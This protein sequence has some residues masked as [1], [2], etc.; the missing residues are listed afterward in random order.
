MNR[1]KFVEHTLKGAGALA[2]TGCRR[3]TKSMG[4]WKYVEHGDSP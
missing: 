3:R 1:R 2:F 4:I